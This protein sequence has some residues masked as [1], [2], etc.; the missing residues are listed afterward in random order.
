MQGERKYG[1]IRIHD[2]IHKI[3]RIEK[4]A[5]TVQEC[6]WNISSAIILILEKI[7][8]FTKIKFTLVITIIKCNWY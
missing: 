3:F 7:R 2:M 8:V 5:P 1:E 4:E 6:E